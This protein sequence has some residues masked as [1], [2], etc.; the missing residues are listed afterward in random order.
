MFAAGMAPSVSFINEDDISYEAARG[1]D[2]SS[3]PNAEPP[4]Q[5]WRDLL[6]D[7]RIVSFAI[8][9]V[10]FYCANA[11]TLPLVGEILSAKNHGKQSAW[12]V[13]AA[14]MWRNW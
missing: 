2:E 1:G 9:V 4:R 10:V 3:D 5:S 14:E 12:Q 11:A 13:A 8:T 7:K 6:K